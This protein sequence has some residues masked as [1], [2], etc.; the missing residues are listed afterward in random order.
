LENAILRCVKNLDIYSKRG[1]TTE[2]NWVKHL[3]DNGNLTTSSVEMKV[4]FDDT[5][6]SWWPVGISAIQF[7]PPGSSE[8]SA[9]QPFVSSMIQ[10][11]NESISGQD[12][13]VKERRGMISYW[14]RAT[15]QKRIYSTPVD[16]HNAVSYSGRKPDIV[17]YDS[18]MRGACAITILGDVKGR[19]SV[20]TDFPDSEIG[21]ILDMASD[22]LKMHHFTRVFM[23]CFL[24]DGYSFQFFKCIRTGENFRYL[25]SGIFTGV[26]GWQVSIYFT[27]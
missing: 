4:F 16:S 7:P 19:R 24:T 26:R 20:A 5:A 23:Y 18:D 14:T 1:V 12:I 21:H 13:V 2:A 15:F 9:C 6:V 10:T 17:C 3:K 11:F 25:Q 8:S 22:L 27:I